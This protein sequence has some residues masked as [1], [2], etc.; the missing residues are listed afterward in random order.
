MLRLDSPV[1]YAEIGTLNLATHSPNT[2]EVDD[3]MLTVAGWG[4]TSEGGDGSTVPMHVDVPYARPYV[5]NAECDASYGW[6]GLVP[7]ALLK[8]RH[9]L[10]MCESHE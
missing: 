4:T 10:L 1:D 7:L 3:V 5:P 9:G 8:W 2:L 6:V